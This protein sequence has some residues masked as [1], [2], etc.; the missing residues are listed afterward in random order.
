M[1]KS[2]VQQIGIWDLPWFC[3][4]SKAA[5]TA[6]ALELRGLEY[7]HVEPAILQGLVQASSAT[8]QR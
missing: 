5:L 1:S 7:K 2:D 6:V 4:P 3:G 8:L